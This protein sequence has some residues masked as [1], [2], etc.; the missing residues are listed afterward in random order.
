MQL[1]KDAKSV[2]YILYKEY[3]NRR[4]HNVSKSQAKSFD[5]AQSIQETFFPNSSLENIE[6]VL[7]ELEKNNFL[8]NFYADGTIYYCSLSDF[9]ITT[10]NS[11]RKENL[12]SIADFIS[13][14]IP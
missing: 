9:A 11:Q 12:L 8:E 4:K 6:D 7:R 13:K 2:L 14:F 5:S 1:T 3:E 10:M